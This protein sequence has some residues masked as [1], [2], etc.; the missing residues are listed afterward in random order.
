MT[1]Q[2]TQAEIDNM[3]RDVESAMQ[4]LQEAQ[5]TQERKSRASYANALG[6][7]QVFGGPEPPDEEYEYRSKVVDYTPQAIPFMPADFSDTPKELFLPLT[8]GRAIIL[9][10]S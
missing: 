8:T 6:I 7:T 5:K 1:K 3:L 4:P 2:K 9:P 10:A